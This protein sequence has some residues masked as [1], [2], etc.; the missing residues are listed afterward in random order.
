M[1]MK[2]HIIVLS[3]I[4]CLFLISVFLY[5]VSANMS[6]QRKV[7]RY[8]EH[9]SQ[10]VEDDFTGINGVELANAIVSYDKS[11]KQY[12]IELLLITDEEISEEQ[13]E[14]YKSVLT[15]TFVDVKLTINGVLR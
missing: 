11:Q 6:E 2:K 14:L 7:E 10:K 15:K 8:S 13:V 1:K 5:K 12:S 4:A 3:V 9:L